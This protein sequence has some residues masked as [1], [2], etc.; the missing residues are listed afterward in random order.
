MNFIERK[1]N[2]DN[3]KAKPV[4]NGFDKDKNINPIHD[5]IK[6]LHTGLNLSFRDIINLHMFC[7]FISDFI[8]DEYNFAFLI[9]LK[10]FQITHHDIYGLLVNIENVRAHNDR[11]T[12][13]FDIEL[14]AFMKYQDIQEQNRY[15]K[16]F[17]LLYDNIYSVSDKDI[18]VYLA[19]Q[20]KYVYSL[21]YPRSKENYKKLEVLKDLANYSNKLFVKTFHQ[22]IDKLILYINLDIPDMEKIK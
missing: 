9:I 5:L 3:I 7:E 17:S 15:L 19:E 12:N 10:A 21:P 18:G 22:Y 14:P 1:F 2:F 13:K 20:E 4:V 6:T 8:E 16:V 11:N